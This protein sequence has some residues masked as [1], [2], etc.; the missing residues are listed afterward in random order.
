[1]ATTKVKEKSDAL[2]TREAATKI[3]VDP[4][5]LRKMLRAS[6]QGVGTGAR[7]EFAPDQLPDL[8]K[9]FA[10][11]SKADEAK[12]AAKKPAPKAKAKQE[13]TPAQV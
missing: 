11:W 1:M 2:S 9:R 12:R 10:A 3:G 4:R 5:A 6:E 13:P 8:K 7:Y